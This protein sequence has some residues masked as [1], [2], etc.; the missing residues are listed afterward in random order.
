MSDK[1]QNE[2]PRPVTY[3]DIIA[4]GKRRVDD[5][6]TVEIPEL[7]GS[8]VLRQ[9]SGAQQDAA[10][11]LATIGE[12][13]DQHRL[14]LEQIKAAL[15]EPAL[16]EEEADEILDNLPIQGFGQLHAA[17]L[18]HSALARIGV[19]DL[20]KQFRV[21][22]ATKRALA[23]GSLA[24]HEGVGDQPTGVGE[25]DTSTD[26]GASSVPQVGEVRAADAGEESDAAAG[27]PVASE[28]AEVE[29]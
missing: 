25:D 7:G 11:A 3:A 23:A 18:A 15:V 28:S 29:S 22:E 1:N 16:P 10:V 12:E 13:I 20:V 27:D 4:I 19:D 5:T 6:K 9:M 17:V 26:D 8:V 14:A 24:D 21:A 2:E